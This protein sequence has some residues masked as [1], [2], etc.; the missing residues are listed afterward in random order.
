MQDLAI[1]TKFKSSIAGNANEGK[2]MTLA[3]KLMNAVDSV[4]HYMT[5]MAINPLGTA[6]SAHFIVKQ[7]II[8][9]ELLDPLENIASGALRTDDFILGRI[10]SYESQIL[11]GHS[12]D[13]SSPNPSANLVTLERHKVWCDMLKILKAK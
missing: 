8:I 13:Q 5:I 1:M 6:Q 4:H 9:D 3:H 7:F 11:A 10:N 2:I 12:I